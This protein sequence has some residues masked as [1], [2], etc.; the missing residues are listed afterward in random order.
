MGVSPYADCSVSPALSLSISVGCLCSLG[1][2]ET[3]R[4]STLPPLPT[5]AETLHSD[6]LPI[7]SGWC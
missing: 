3:L 6:F 1:A 4:L 7:S 2:L 5:Q